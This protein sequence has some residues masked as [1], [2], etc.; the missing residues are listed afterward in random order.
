MGPPI[1]VQ[2]FVHEEKISHIK[3]F[4]KNCLGTQWEIFS[5]IPYPA[6]EKKIS[7]WMGQYCSGREPSIT[8]PFAFSA[9]PS[10]TTRVLA[11]IQ[12]ISFGKCVS[13]KELALQLK[14]P[15]GCRAVGNACGRNPFPLIVPCHRILAH[16]QKIGGYALDLNLKKALL[17]FEGVPFSL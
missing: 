1:E 5:D 17:E 6:L 7:T 16:N 9:L 12:S 4:F 2:F 11:A 13:Y 15:R 10:F 3:L 8:L 14:N